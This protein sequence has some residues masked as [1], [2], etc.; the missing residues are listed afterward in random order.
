MNLRNVSKAGVE[1]SVGLDI[2]TNSVGWAVIDENGELLHFKGK[3]T[4]GSRMFPK[5]NTAADAR[6]RRGQRRRYERRRWR[7]HL[8]QGFFAKEM[9][10]VDAE[11]FIR[12]NQTHLW[13]D[14]KHSGA[15]QS[16]WPLFNNVD[17]TE[18]DYY[19]RFPTIFHLRQW[20]IETDDKADIRLVY[21]ALHNI[22]KHRG[23]FLQQDNHTLSAR[24]ADMEESLQAFYEAL[25]EWCD[26]KGLGCGIDKEGVKKLYDTSGKNR[27]SIADD[28]H[29][30]PALLGLTSP[31]DGAV[32]AKAAAKEIGKALAGRK[33]D[34]AKIFCDIEA[35]KTSFKLGDE[36]GPDA[37]AGLCDGSDA[38]LFEAMSRVYSS[39]VLVGML[40]KKGYSLSKVDAYERYAADLA[41]LKELVRQ[42]A[43]D[44]YFDFFR[45]PLH[46]DGSGYDVS[47]AQGYT[48]YNLGP[49]KKASGAKAQSYDDFRKS[50]EKL[51]LG[52]EAVADIRYIDM[53]ERFADEKFLRRLRTSDNGP[54]PFQLNLEEMTLILENQGRHYPFL[55]EH[56]N[57]IESLVRFRIPYYIGPLTHK[58]AARDAYGNKRF[59]WSVRKEG[60]EA[61]VITPWNWESVI[62]KNASAEAFIKRM[63]GTCSY[64]EGE[65]VLPRCSLLYEEYCVLNELNG[66]R[67]TQDGDKFARFDYAD[68]V[69]IVEDLFS[70][71]K[72]TYAHVEDWLRQRGRL[73]PHVEGGQG[74]K[75]FESKLSSYI[76]FCKDVFKVDALPE[77]WKPKLEEIILWNTLFED[78]GILREKIESKYGDWLTEEQIKIICKKRFTG[79]G[80]LSEKLLTELRARTDNGPRA[81]LELL[82]EGDQNNTRVGRAMVMQEILHDDMLGFEKLI[83]DVN[84]EHRRGAG[85]F[86]VNDLPGSPA[87]RRSINQAVRIVEE[88]VGIAG[89]APTNIFI[90]VTRD[91]DTMKKGKRTTTRYKNIEE[92]LKSLGVEGSVALSEL[93][94]IKPPDLDKRLT[95]YFMQNGKSLYSGEPLDIRH[96]EQYQ[97]DHIIPQSYIKDGSFE[98]LALV[99]SGENQRKSNQMLIAG[100]IRRKMSSEWRALYE[101]KLIGR[102]KFENLMRTNVSEKQM[103]GFIARQLVETSQ[104]VKLVQRVLRERYPE[105]EVR[106]TKA[107]LSSQLRD[108]A[109][110]VKCREINDYHHAHDAYLACQIGRFIQLRHPYVYDNPIAMA[111]VMRSYVRNQWEQLEKTGKI[112]GSTSKAGFLIQSFLRPGFDEETG[113]VLQDAW[114]PSVEIARIRK[115]L[116]YRDCYIS[117]MPEETGGAF[118]DAT[119]YSP[120]SGKKLALPVKQSLSVERYGGYSSEQFAYFFV[121]KTYSSKKKRYAF[122]YEA[123]PVR[124]AAAIAASE[125]ALEKYA[126]ALCDDAGVEFVE[127]ARPKVYKY[128]LIELE[129]NRLFI[130]GKKEVRSAV[131]FA[132]SQEETA[133]IGG[134]LKGEAS[135]LEDRR[136]IL[137][138]LADRF[139][140]YAKKLGNS[141]NV[142]SVVS[143]FEEA[144]EQEQGHVL[145]SLVS[146]AAAK[147]NMIDLPSVG[148]SKCSGCMRV[149]FSKE[150]STPR[151]NPFAFIDQSVTGMFESR[152]T[153]EL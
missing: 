65:P 142:E 133:L 1:Y 117:R 136:R 32:N 22:V 107:S 67:W 78:R 3:P 55:L 19:K 91:D 30:L 60:E 51:F 75:G 114:N 12:L 27:S 23:N 122:E 134:I 96:L 103:K 126:R 88:I 101:A 109:G 29:G 99:L 104:M 112:A 59:A 20:L 135:S 14:D 50:V 120:Q 68:R 10:S 111:K 106:P 31:A 52:T 13:G 115:C 53:M 35:E 34:F 42:Y 36:E 43:P 85:E 73:N 124:V 71:R 61:S 33:A 81:I 137:A 123:V 139:N 4:W 24:N 77:E 87:L 118:W 151:T 149:T 95:L 38:L 9:E 39:Y 37:F 113:E 8:L 5:A 72:V 41:A 26:E 6:L 62:D 84:A 150:L 79:W 47:R 127:I 90:E 94:G 93:N 144:S 28:K 18:A 11:F 69:G 128:Q 70:H 89:K 105:T 45:G 108:V 130:T 125:G 121:Y 110:F 17:F 138:A 80:R 44:G 102:K 16:R 74:E 153:L 64:L 21:L 119:V 145:L 147:T 116:E 54:V 7:L 97:I 66:A 131:Q 46:A 49:N 98:N 86:N 58:N 140:R 83:E 92:A 132:F 129:G 76:F 40:T 152:Q 146:I 100:D 148:G 25:E 82:R 63:T 141:L 57:E 48:L 143:R 15:D 2:G 56:K